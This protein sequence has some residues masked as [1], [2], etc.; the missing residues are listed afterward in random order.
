MAAWGLLGSIFDTNSGTHTVTA[1]PAVGDLIVIV[2]QGSN[3]IA[4]T[5]PTDD[6]PD[7]LGTYT[8][9]DRCA[10]NSN[11]STARV[12]VRDALIGNAASTIFTHAPGT[13]TG[14]GLAV[15]KIT[16]MSRAGASAIAKSGRQDNASSGTTPTVSW[17]GGGSASG[18]NP[19]LGAVVHISTTPFTK[20]STFD[21]ERVDASYTTPNCDIE[22]ATDDTGNTDSTVTW[23]SNYAGGGGAVIVEFDSTA[24][25]TA[26][27]PGTIA[28]SVTMSDA[29][30]FARGLKIADSVTM[31][32]AIKFARGLMIAD[33]VTMSDNMVAGFRFTR[34]VNDSVTMADAITKFGYGRTVADSVTVSDAIKFARAWNIADSVTMA[35]AVKF[36]RGLRVVDTVTMADVIKF[37]RA[38][39]I[40]D[41]VALSDF[42]DVEHFN[43]LY[44]D[45]HC[46]TPGVIAAS[47]ITPDVLTANCITPDSLVATCITPDGSLTLVCIS[48]DGSITLIPSDILS[49]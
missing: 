13:T 7:G 45:L 39:R 20:P 44:P 8:N 9:V 21:T 11:A 41:A 5:A 42:I 43:P 29:V 10:Y 33:S 36:A 22:I 1:T 47:C 15:F 35:D 17:T 40:A 28:D 38:L 19:V 49:G 25:G 34:S 12:F 24:A 27:N 18:S 31:A 32:D 3:Y 16:S 26:W 48:P 30:K 4:T 14:G 46:I 23:G 37:S 2:I 6:N